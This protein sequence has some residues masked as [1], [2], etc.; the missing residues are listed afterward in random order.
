M[1]SANNPLLFIVSEPVGSP[2]A[3]EIAYRLADHGVR[4]WIGS[5]AP[6]GELKDQAVKV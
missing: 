3:N 2:A 5:L 4:T 6:T 1:A